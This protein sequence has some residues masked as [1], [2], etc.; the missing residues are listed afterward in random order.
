[1]DRARA[2]KLQ[3]EALFAREVMRI[4]Q[5]LNDALAKL[6][7][8]LVQQL[9][10]PSRVL[11]SQAHLLEALASCKALVDLTNGRARM[12]KEEFDDIDL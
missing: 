9:D 3:L 10:D 7:E 12:L 4:G 5:E 1:M 11:V 2:E 8:S 6:N